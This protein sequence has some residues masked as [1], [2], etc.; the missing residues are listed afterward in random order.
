MSAHW[1][2]AREGSGA[3][4][5]KWEDWQEALTATTTTTV[6]ADLLKGRPL[7]PGLGK[8]RHGFAKRIDFGIDVTEFTGIKH[9]S[10]V[11]K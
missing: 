7:R 1:V 8:N 6:I 9:K 10:R 2:N 5:M 11:S 4:V 3:T